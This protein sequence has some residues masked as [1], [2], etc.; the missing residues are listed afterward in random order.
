[1]FEQTASYNE[2]KA[3]VLSDWPKAKVISR[4]LWLQCLAEV[5]TEYGVEP[6]GYQ[7]YSKKEYKDCCFYV[8]Q[9]MGRTSMGLRYGLDGPEYFSPL[10]DQKIASMVYDYISPYKYISRFQAHTEILVLSE[11]KDILV[12]TRHLIDEDRVQI[13]NPLDAM[14]R[15]SE[16]ELLIDIRLD[17]LKQIES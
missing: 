17:V 1:M 13:K 8:L 14:N 2:L 15:I 10:A 5:E 6:N 7:I 12:N 9:S 3:K 16:A 11:I 4:E